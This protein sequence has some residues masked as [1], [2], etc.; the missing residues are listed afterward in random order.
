MCFNLTNK[1]RKQ[2]NLPELVWNEKLYEIGLQHSKDMANQK[3]P[4]GHKG[5]NKR[6]NQ[7]D[8]QI[9]GVFF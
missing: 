4:F 7:V 2:K 1:F 9:S 6:K 8:F 5:F 3:V